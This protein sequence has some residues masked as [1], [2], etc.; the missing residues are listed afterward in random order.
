MSVVLMVGI[1]IMRGHLI[2]GTWHREALRHAQEREAKAEARSDR[3][4]AVA[5][6]ALDATEKLTEPVEIAAKVM[7]RLPNVGEGDSRR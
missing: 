7:T 2:P 1:L 6:R 3:W 4:E 5:L